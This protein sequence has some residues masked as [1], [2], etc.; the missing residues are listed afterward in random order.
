MKTEA[1]KTKERILKL[2][3]EIK[4]IIAKS[5]GQAFL[6]KSMLNNLKLK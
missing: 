1:N 5:N 2:N 4:K 6:N 3:A